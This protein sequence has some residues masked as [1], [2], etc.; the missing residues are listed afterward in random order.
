MDGNN[1]HS[2]ARAVIEAAEVTI[3]TPWD[4]E[5]LV[6]Y[7]HRMLEEFTCDGTHRFAEQFRD[8][9]ARRATALIRRLSAKG[10]CCCDCEMFLNTYIL[11]NRPLVLHRNRVLA[12]PVRHS[13]GLIDPELM[14]WCQGVQGG[15]TQACANWVEAKSL[16]T[17]GSYSSYRWFDGYGSSRDDDVFG[18]YGSVG[19]SGRRSRRGSSPAY[20]SA[21]PFEWERP[22]DPDEANAE[23]DAAEIAEATEAEEMDYFDTPSWGQSW[24]SPF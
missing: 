15:S 16:K 12:R 14:L 18:S 8:V 11:G 17:Y 22:L 10:A 1:A 23:A 24:S 20:G 13:L 4:G 21:E 9:R 19:S 2:D 6:C 3:L 5:C 7:C